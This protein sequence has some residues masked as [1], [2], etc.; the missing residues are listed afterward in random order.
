MVP[1]ISPSRSTSAT[2]AS[3]YALYDYVEDPDDRF[4]ERLGLDPGGELYKV[5]DTLASVGTAEKKN[6]LTDDKDSLNTLIRGV[7]GRNGVEDLTWIMDN[8]NIAQMVNF[9]VGFAI[10]SNRDWLP[11][12]LLCLSRHHG[13]RRMVVPAVGRGLVT[14]KKLGL[15][16]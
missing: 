12:E 3:F 2:T 9:E 1:T 11:Q 6:G 13:Y 7:Q 15:A 4:L 10:T 8:V 14:R 5:Y 16:V